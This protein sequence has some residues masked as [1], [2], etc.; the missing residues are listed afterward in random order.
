MP[1]VRTARRGRFRLV[2][3]CLERLPDFGQ[4]FRQLGPGLV[5]PRIDLQR[6]DLALELG[7]Q[8]RS[9]PQPFA[10]IVKGGHIAPIRDQGFG[11][12]SLT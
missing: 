1:M 11:G 9:L 12:G 10:P 6:S 4:H 7:H 3:Q 2:F 8:F 5:R